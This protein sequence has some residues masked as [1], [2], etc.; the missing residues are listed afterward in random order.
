[1]SIARVGAGETLNDGPAHA[2]A[3]EG[4]VKVVLATPPAR[5]TERWPPLGLLYIASSL[6]TLRAD[7]VRVVDAF[8]E[9]LSAEELTARVVRERPDVFGMNCSTHTFLG[10]IATL[11]AVRRALPETELVMG[12]YHATFAAERILRAYPCV[13]VV[14]KGEAEHAFPQLLDR[15]EAG[16][17]LRDVDGVSVVED[18][19]LVDR[20]TAVIQDLD[21]LPFPDRSLLAGVDYGYAYRD[22]PLTHGRF[23]TICSSRGCPFSCRYCSCATFSMRRWRARSARNVVDEIEAL[24]QDGYRSAVF[25][26]DN[27]TLDRGRVH[28]ICDLLQERKVRMRFY[29]EGR[30]DNAPP[31][32]LRAMKRAGFDVIYFGVE[33]VSDHVLKYYDK[34]ISAERSRRA[35]E[36]AKRAGMLVVASFIIGAPVESREDILRT[37]EFIERTRPHAAQVNILDCLIGTPIWE[38]MVQAGVVGPEDWKRN[39]RIYEY[40]KVGPSQAELEEL[41]DRGYA[42]HIEGW[43]NAE[44]LLDLCRLLGS[45]PTGRRTVLGAIPRL[46]TV[47]RV[48][49]E[50][51]AKYNGHAPPS[52][53]A[54]P[55]D[56]L[57][58]WGEETYP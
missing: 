36:D 12:G 34:R 8:C 58:R 3:G 41:R 40:N 32:L 48:S 29:C 57:A 37:I 33:S 51:D 1:M 39:H 10:T 54:G 43:E 24:R 7:D 2:P 17:S 21:A 15:L 44:G 13:D 45:N 47:L 53:R 28:E 38:E 56:R 30:V 26:D 35:I 16:V 19:R 55:V 42:A 49:A 52:G 31:E 18:G 27:F 50:A 25:V 5:T 46:S 23:T 6:R 22:I 9:G 14:L 11:K 20:P 4:E